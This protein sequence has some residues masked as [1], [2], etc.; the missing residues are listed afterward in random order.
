MN[1][2]ETAVVDPNLIFDRYKYEAVKKL[3]PF[4]YMT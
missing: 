1:D 4:Y 2:K 3:K